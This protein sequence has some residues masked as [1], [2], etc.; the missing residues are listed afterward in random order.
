MIKFVLILAFFTQ[1]DK[2]SKTKHLIK[3]KEYDNKNKTKL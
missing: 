1:K 2:T 3:D